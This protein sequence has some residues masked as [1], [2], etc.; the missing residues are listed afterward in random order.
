[1]PKGISQELLQVLACPKCKGGLKYAANKLS[2]KKCRKAYKV[3]DGVPVM[4]V[5]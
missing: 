4:L 1:M 5:D 2:C 3:K